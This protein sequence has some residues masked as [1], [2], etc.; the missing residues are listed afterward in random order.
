MEQRLTEDGLSAECNGFND[1]GAATDTGVEKDGEFARV[2][3]LADA[4]MGCDLLQSDEC[5]DGSIDL[6]STCTHRIES[7]G[8]PNTRAQDREPEERKENMCPPWFE[9]T[10]PSHPTS[11]AFNAS[12]TCKIPFKT[13]GPSQCFL[14]N[15]NSSHVLNNPE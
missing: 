6:T 15:S 4:W 8:E 7:N 9:T 13:N 1:I 2:L 3:G 5:R 10:I 14:T 11:K 12:S